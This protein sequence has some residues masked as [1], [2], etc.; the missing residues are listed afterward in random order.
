MLINLEYLDRKINRRT[1]L[2]GATVVVLAMHVLMFW[3]FALTRPKVLDWE[4]HPP[5]D[6]IDVEL[7]DV[8]KPEPKPELIVIP[9]LRAPQP[10]VRNKQAA[11]EPQIAPK[12][13]T[14]P[15]PVPV[16]VSQPQ[17]VPKPQVAPKPQPVI[18]PVPV[19]EVAPSPIIRAK[20]KKTDEPLQAKA[21]APEAVTVNDL[22]LHETTTPV[23]SLVPPSGL[24]PPASQQAAGS[25]APGGGAN[26]AAGKVDYGALRGGRGQVTQALQNHGSCVSIQI[27]GRTVPSD[28]K[29][30]GLAD[31]SP[32]GPPPNS[33]L[34]RT[35]AQKDAY[36]KYKTQPGNSDYWQRVNAAPDNNKHVPD[37]DLHKGAYSDEKNRRVI[38]G[39][40]TDPKNDIGPK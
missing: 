37:P 18:A 33:D 3:G 28:C 22:N 12:P 24:T 4:M 36:L 27:K 35:V 2:A 29:M 19:P 39:L 15:D 25:A 32:L 16:P 40:D 9:K 5:P 1:R 34:Q 38:N 31:M 8:Q 10:Q 30:K 13:Q 23:P 14:V 11:A 17:V 20:P 21:T 6:A 26:G 7:Y